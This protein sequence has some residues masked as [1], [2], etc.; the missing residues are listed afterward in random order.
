MGYARDGQR[1][2]IEAPGHLHESLRAIGCAQKSGVS[3]GAKPLEQKQRQQRQQLALS[4][5]CPVLGTVLTLLHPF[6]L[7]LFTVP[8][9]ADSV[10][11]PILLG[12][13]RSLREEFDGGCAAG[14]CVDR[15]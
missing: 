13:K 15:I 6:L 7:L 1:V 3:V 4:E 14:K 12:R 8:R 11:I 9:E 2:S 5:P 10:I